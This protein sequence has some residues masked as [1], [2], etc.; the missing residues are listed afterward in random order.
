MALAGKL[1]VLARAGD[2]RPEIARALE[3]RGARARTVRAVRILPPDDVAP[4]DAALREIEGFDWIV[5]SSA[6]AARAVGERLIAMGLAWPP[7]RPRI[8]AVGAATAMVASDFLRTPDLVPER[9]N[10]EGVVDALRGEAVGKRFLLPRSSIGRQEI[11]R[12]LRGAGADVAPVI[13]YRAE[14]AGPADCPPWLADLPRADAIAFASP[15]TL[16]GLER[17]LG[18]ER[19]ERLAG[20]SRI[21]AMGPT[22]AAAIRERGLAVA[23]VAD[24]PDADGLVD[25]IAR[26][27][28]E[29]AP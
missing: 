7:A 22:T 3:A 6:N 26:A 16:R 25:A 18:T 27:L 14:P 29:E 28:G 15:S 23:A 2:P 9:G 8:A 24:P 17:M 10:A 13:A 21:L 5:L 1:V 11:E 20:M 12:G 4:L 19:F